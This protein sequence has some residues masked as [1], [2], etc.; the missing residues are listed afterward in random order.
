M[1]RLFAIGTSFSV[2]ILATSPG[3]FASAN[4]VQNPDFESGLNDWIV[5]GPNVNYNWGANRADVPPYTGDSYSGNYAG[6]GCGPGQNCTLYQPLHTTPGETYTLSF[7]FNPGYCV[8]PD[9]TGC[10]PDYL[11]YG[12]TGGLKVYFNG[13][14]VTDIANGNQGWTLYTFTGLDATQL[15]TNVGFHGF[16]EPDFNAVADVSVTASVP[17][18]STWAMMLLGFSGLGFAGYRRARAGHATLAA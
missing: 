13:I 14:L 18:A 12:T 3:A 1:R 4:I 2:I 17:E 8:G 7:A 16:Q 9:L 10:N 5:A 6:E 11:Q 15:L